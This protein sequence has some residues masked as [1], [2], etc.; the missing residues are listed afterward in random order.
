MVEEA[1]VEAAEGGM[2]GAV[3]V[4][5]EEDTASQE[6]IFRKYFRVEKYTMEIIAAP[7]LLLSLANRKKR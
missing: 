2:E 4:G 6:L 1:A 7:S 5:A 3:D